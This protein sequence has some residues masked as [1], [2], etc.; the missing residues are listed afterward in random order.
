MDLIFYCDE[1]CHIQFDHVEYMSL[2]TVFCSKS[3]T[4]NI[5]RDIRKIKEKYRIDTNQELKWTKISNSNLQLY[6]EI[7]NYISEKTYI[8]VRAVLA[9]KRSVDEF[10]LRNKTYDQWYHSIYYY[11]LKHPLDLITEAKVEFDDCFLFI[12]KKDIYTN[13]NI[14][15]LANYLNRHF[16]YIH[17]FI[18]KAVE[19]HE[20]QLV[21]VAD[22]I[23]GALTYRKRFPQ[24]NTPKNELC[25]FIEEKLGPLSVKSSYKSINY[26]LLIMEKEEL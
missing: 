25:N 3:R 15:I 19:S 10:K 23:A 13:E 6:K 14:N 21:Q 7:I 9:K 22:I 17:N 20:H 4:K 11:L 2:V 5:N 16:A 26:N 24:S 8:R 1:S 12:D 18:P